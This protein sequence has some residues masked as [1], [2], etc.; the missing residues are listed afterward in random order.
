MYLPENHVPTPEIFVKWWDSLRPEE[1]LE[2]AKEI[3]E[4]MDTSNTCVMNNHLGEIHY[5]H[6]ELGYAHSG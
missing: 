2:K 1:K 3:T 4:A 6:E 5:L